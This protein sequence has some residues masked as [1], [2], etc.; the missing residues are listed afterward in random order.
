MDY[1]SNN[2]N[3]EHILPEG[4]RVAASAGTPYIDPFV[5]ADT[6]VAARDAKREALKK[7]R[8]ARRKAKNPAHRILDK[9]F[10]WTVYENNKWPPV[11]TWESFTAYHEQ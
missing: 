10:E 6:L 5:M 9:A 2:D 8:R 1:P 4:I 3:N 11:P 7:K